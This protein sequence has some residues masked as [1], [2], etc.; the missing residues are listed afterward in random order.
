MGAR[1]ATRNAPQTGRA[2][3]LPR[4][5]WRARRPRPGA[6]RWL[7]PFG[8]RKGIRTAAAGPGPRRR[9]GV[10]RRADPWDE[11]GIQR[12]TTRGTAVKY[13]DRWMRPGVHADVRPLGRRSQ[14]P[15]SRSNTRTVSTLK[16]TLAELLQNWPPASGG[17][18]RPQRGRFQAAINGPRDNRGPWRGFGHR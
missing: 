12:P 4:S 3:A 9:S 7:S 16:G 18:G 6:L 5:L 1:S 10:R 17:R 8:F 11:P 15:R 2:D 14:Y 13:V